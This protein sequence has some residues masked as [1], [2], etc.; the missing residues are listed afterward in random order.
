MEV[1]WEVQYQES[2]NPV[3]IFAPSILN[4]LVSPE[5]IVGILRESVINNHPNI[6]V[7]D[8]SYVIHRPNMLIRRCT[9]IDRWIEQRWAEPANPRMWDELRNHC[10]VVRNLDYAEK[11]TLELLH[12]DYI[13][14]LRNSRA[15]TLRSLEELQEQK[16]RGPLPFHKPFI[17]S[18]LTKAITQDGKPPSRAL[19]AAPKS[20]IT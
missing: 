7:R 14:F 2:Q 18:P 6:T 10:D 9:E 13:S 12:P 3:S 1:I 4:P 5:D 15:R 8:F 19:T 16:T 11:N 20:T 17:S